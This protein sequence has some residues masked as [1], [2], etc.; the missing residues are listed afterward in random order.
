MGLR[1][2]KFL[3]ELIDFAVKGAFGY[4]AAKKTAMQT[5]VI[6]D[7]LFLEDG[8][9]V[10]EFLEMYDARIYN[11][12]NQQ[13]DLKFMKGNDFE[14]VYILHNLTKE[15]YFVG[16]SQKVFRKVERHFNGFGNA[17]LYEDWKNGNAF[18]VRMIRL[19][20][21]NH[22]DLQSLEKEM[23]SKYGRYS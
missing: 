5:R 20:G 19:D 13:Y 18:T 10:Q 12:E 7:K 23:V 3:I 1:M 11:P 15:K 16:R 21:T 4:S 9:S 6:F 2:G 22:F 8:V 14:G 17:L